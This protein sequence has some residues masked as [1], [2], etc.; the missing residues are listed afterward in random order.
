MI[1][2][3]HVSSRV[4]GDVVA[5]GGDVFLEP[6]AQVRGDVVA[7]GGR[8]IGKGR[9]EGR[10]VDVASLTMG[11]LA[12]SQESP[13]VR[14]GLAFLHLGGWLLVVA[15]AVLVA[16]RQVR[17]AGL[18]LREHGWRSGLAGVLAL[19]AWL[20]VAILALAVSETPLG[21]LAVLLAIGVLLFAKLVGL[22][23]V[24]WLGGLLLSPVLPR[25]FRGETAR[26]GVAMLG[27]AAISLLPF[28]G[29]AV[30]IAANVAG[31]GACVG[32]LLS[33]VPLAVPLARLATR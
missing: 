30:W 22:A 17:E 20:A 3:V 24:A 10:R 13:S 2:A 8:V 29:P 28:V 21:L 27:M 33:R 7:L 26:T 5:V 25:S 16:P 6:T 23:A 4:E 11:A 31:V 32:L 14:L 15:L 18:G 19:T 1:A 12:G 9:V